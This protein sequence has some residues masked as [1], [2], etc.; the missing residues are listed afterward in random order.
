MSIMEGVNKPG[1]SKNKDFQTLF[2]MFYRVRRDEDWRKN[3]YD[4]FE[5]AKKK[6]FTFEDILSELYKYEHHVEASFAS[7]MI[8][9]IDTQKPIWDKNVLKALGLKLTGQGETRIENA[10]GIYKE[11]EKMFEDYMNTKECKKNIKEFDQMLPSYSDIS[12]V[13]KID[14]LL[15]C[16]GAD[17]Q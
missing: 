3:F 7:K 11:I 6:G 13:K 17:D 9:T 8:A 1:F 16:M 15:W 12:C 10:K 5:M 2:N 14:Y 4:V